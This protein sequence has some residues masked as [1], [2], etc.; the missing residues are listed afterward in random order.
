MKTSAEEKLSESEIAEAIENVI[1]EDLDRLNSL[2]KRGI[3][4]VELHRKIFVQKRQV[5]ESGVQQVFGSRPLTSRAIDGLYT[6][7]VDVV[8]RKTRIPSHSGVVIAGFGTKD[9]FPALSA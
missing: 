5:I 9:A 6:I 3:S 8:L 1:L 2:E 7:A 4:N